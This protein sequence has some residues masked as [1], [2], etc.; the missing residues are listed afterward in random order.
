M[1]KQKGKKWKQ[2]QI[3]FSWALKSLRTVIAATKLKDACSLEESYDKPIQCIKKQR[4]HLAAKGLYSQSYDFSSSHVQE[5]WSIRKVE[6]KNWCFW[7]VVVAS[8]LDCKEIK[9]VNP[10][11]NQPWIFT[12]RIVAE[13]EAPILWL[14]DAKSQRAGK[15]PD[16]G[17]DWRQKE[18][19]AAEDKMVRQHHQLKGHEFE[20]TLGDSRAQR[21]LVCCS[22][23][24]SQRVC[25]CKESDTT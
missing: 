1:A 13:V 4:H 7:T 14:P 8:T 6:A 23:C 3:L 19:R 24:E 18:K 20:Q 17:K 11:E 21:S 10:K 9:L 16:A 15:D 12:G 25:S 22:P 2:W 5:S